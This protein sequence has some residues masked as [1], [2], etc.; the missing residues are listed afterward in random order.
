MAIENWIT[1]AEK[2]AI[3]FIVAGM[4][5]HDMY[6]GKTGGDVF[7]I[8]MSM[9]KKA[10]YKFQGCNISDDH[11]NI[12]ALSYSFEKITIDP[13]DTDESIDLLA[14]AVSKVTE[15]IRA[16]LSSDIQDTPQKTGVYK[17]YPF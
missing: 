12:V 5:K 1:Q 6:L 9:L 16:L 11:T 2:K 14:S 4:T 8:P 10:G 3:G 17:V 7:R 13:L 15:E